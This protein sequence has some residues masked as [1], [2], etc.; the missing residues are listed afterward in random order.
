MKWCSSLYSMSSVFVGVAA[1]TLG[2]MTS[3]RAESMPSNPV[4][5]VTAH[6]IPA[7]L[8]DELSGLNNAQLDLIQEVLE[9]PSVTDPLFYPTSSQR[10]F[11]EGNDQ[12]EQEIQRLSDTD[13]LPEPPL[14]V[15]PEV[16]EQFEEE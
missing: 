7:P 8:M 4:S 5:D 6:G 11:E 12:F 1:I 16:L 9:N 10:F 2:C 15:Q 14:T 13:E 3:A